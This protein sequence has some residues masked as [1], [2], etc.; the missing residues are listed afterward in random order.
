[1]R[2]VSV[3]SSCLPW[4]FLLV[5]RQRSDS[6]NFRPEHT[7][8][9]L[10]PAWVNDSSTSV[11]AGRQHQEQDYFSSA[12]RTLQEGSVVLA[13]LSGLSLARDGP[14]TKPSLPCIALDMKV[15]TLLPDPF[16]VQCIT[17]LHCRVSSDKYNISQLSF[18]NHSSICQSKT[19]SGH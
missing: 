15:N 2:S 4:C 9:I 13:L 1:M 17:D 10:C 18:C 3:S 19:P 16:D 5:Y 14:A 8:S 6:I 12:P 7:S 11:Q